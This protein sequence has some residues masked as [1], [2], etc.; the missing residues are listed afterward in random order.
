MKYRIRTLSRTPHAGRSLAARRAWF[1]E[2][3]APGSGTSGKETGAGSGTPA[4]SGAGSGTSTPQSDKTGEPDDSKL[5]LEDALKVIKDLRASEA[6]IRRSSKE[7][8][9]AQRRLAE[10]ETANKAAEEKRLADQ[11]DYKTLYEK[12]KA[13]REKA[14]SDYAG[15]SLSALKTRVAVETGLPPKWADRLNGTTEDELRAD[16]EDLLKDMPKKEAEQTP[17]GQQPGQRRTTPAFPSGKPVAETDEA[18]RS[19]LF[20]K[21]GSKS[22]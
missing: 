5:T 13:A 4:G 9:D 10:L 14:E 12:E 18:R 7:G 1:A 6:K 16:A 20:G 15:A 17:A 11:N 22:F 19:R 3:P 2:T 8:K 21:R